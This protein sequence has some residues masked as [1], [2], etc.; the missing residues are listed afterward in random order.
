MVG[1]NTKKAI[2]IYPKFQ[3]DTFWSFLRTLEKYVPRGEHGLPKR[4]MPPLGLMGLY[5]HLNKNYIKEGYYNEI[6]LVDRNVDPRPLEEVVARYDHVYMG[7]MIAQEEGFIEDASIIKEKFPEKTIIVGGTAVDETSELMRIAD[8]LIENEAEM[9]ID[10]L[11]EGIFNGTAKKYYKGVPAP[12]EKFFIPDYTSINLDNYVNIG[13]Q[14]S[15]GCPEDCEFCDITARF[16]R[17]PRLTPWEHIETV[18]KQLYDLDAKM[19]LFIVDD[20]FIG[21]PRLAIETLKK[22]Y[23]LEEELGY[24]FPKYTE[25]TMRVGEDSSMMSELRKW[26][27]KTNLNMYFVGV[28]SNN[29]EALIETGKVQNLRGE[30]S[31]T[32]KLMDISKKTGATITS[33]MILGFDNDTLDSV[34]P[35]IEFINSTHIPATMV[36]LLNALPYTKLWERLEKGGRLSEKSAG[37]NSDGRINFIPMEMSAK[38]AEEA[39]VR[40]LKGIYNRKSFFGRVMKELSVFDP[41]YTHDVR[42]KEETLYI[43]KKLLTDWKH[44]PT[45]LWHALRAHKIAKKRFGFMSPKYMYSMGTYFTHCA[46]YIHYKGQTKHLERELKQ[47][48]Y[49]PWQLYS[50]KDIQKAKIA[51]IDVIEDEMKEPS[52]F[53]K[54]KMTL[55]NGYE[56][57]GTRLDAL[58]HFVEPHLKERMEKLK[59]IKVPSLKNFID[60]EVKAYLDAHFKRPKILGKTDFSKVEKHLREGYK[61]EPGYFSKMR[62]LYR[63]AVRS[64]RLKEAHSKQGS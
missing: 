38:E 44:T 46:K 35:F 13:I 12:P 37:N 58:K 50:W 42:P 17:I 28:E 22:F 2:L 14:L 60:T 34:D 55:E 27:R 49:E 61:K 9:V 32:D 54:V 43:A 36:G 11:V 15:R 53:E 56:F 10:E 33:G 30:E 7:G 8:H 40:I 19:S 51:S 62:T 20:N 59:D 31:M 18:I 16:G 24:H 63:N 21:N 5:N 48:K 1:K 4:F 23:R 64:I 29:I 41:E 26:L 39:Y 45:F 3:G 52:I 6:V 57:V 25:L 47:R